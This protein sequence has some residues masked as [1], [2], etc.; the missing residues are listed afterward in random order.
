MQKSSNNSRQPAIY[1]FTLV[2]VLVTIS[3]I[4]VLIALA[5]PPLRTARLQ[6]QS[7]ECLSRLKGL[8]E[9]MVIIEGRNGGSWPN[10]F[11][12]D[13]R[14]EIQMFTTGT[15][16]WGVYYFGQVALWQGSFVGVLW[17][18]GDPAEVWTCPAVMR[19]GWG[20]RGGREQ[21]HEQQASGGIA[22]YFY[23][24][25]LIS[26]PAMWDPTDPTVRED[27]PGARRLVGVHEVRFPSRKASMAEV[28]D[29]HG[30][31]VRMAIEE[32]V[33]AL[34]ALFADGHAERSRA[35]DATPGL[36]TR[37]MFWFDWG[38]VVRAPFLGTPWG[39]HGDDLAG[40]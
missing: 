29:F 27:R 28:A 26:E 25:G 16:Q 17:D 35:A 36:P 32:D 30:R 40:R 31:S 1:G 13:M 7:S 38:E 21:L 22:S 20:L 5:I 3:I 39:A 10:L 14:G 23:S 15:T 9:G 19:T 8:G 37:H 18:E 6:A 24:P 11:R 33:D 34:N 4:A 2:E 12:R